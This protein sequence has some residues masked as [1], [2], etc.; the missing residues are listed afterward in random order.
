MAKPRHKPEV[1]A[2]TPSPDA[3]LSAPA[4]GRAH[5]LADDLVTQFG[6]DKPGVG[7]A[8]IEIQRM[9]SWG[10]TI[11]PK[12]AANCIAHFVELYR[13][14]ERLQQE[15]LDRTTHNSVV[16]YMRLGD[17]VKIGVTINLASRM[18]DIRPEEL[19]AAE[20]G[21]RSI[22]QARHRQFAH[23]R[24]SGEWFRLEAPLTDFIEALREVEAES[25]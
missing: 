3:G 6:L 14:I 5:P 12:I 13:R 2:R 4:K 15:R 7:R 17:R 20:P 1:I 11:T 9:R 21:D 18:A 22:E 23:L 10:V 25:A 19:M 8:L 16:Y 24:T